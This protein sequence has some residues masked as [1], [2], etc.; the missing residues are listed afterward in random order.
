MIELHDVTDLWNQ[1]VELE[2]Q[3]FEKATSA[4]GIITAYQF[5][6][7][8]DTQGNYTNAIASLMYFAWLE[9]AKQEFTRHRLN[10][11]QA[12]ELLQTKPVP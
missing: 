9:R 1:T 5:D 11:H 4:V 12:L 7:T 2:K 10:L 3:A 8:K 6:Y